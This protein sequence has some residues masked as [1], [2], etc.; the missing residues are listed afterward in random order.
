MFLFFPIACSNITILNK[1]PGAKL[2]FIIPDLWVA[3]M[4]A[5]FVTVLWSQVRLK[6]G[7]HCIGNHFDTLRKMVNPSGRLTVSS[8]FEPGTCYIQ[9]QRGTVTSAFLICSILNADGIMGKQQLS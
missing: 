7:V 3:L 5:Q 2:K 1:L 9:V 6:C 4:M 8:S